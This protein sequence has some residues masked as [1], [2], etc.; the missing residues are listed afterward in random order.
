MTIPRSCI[1][2]LWTRRTVNHPSTP[3]RP[4]CP[5]QSRR[6][7]PTTDRRRRLHLRARRLAR[8][9]AGRRRRLHRRIRRRRQKT[10]PSI[11]LRRRTIA[12]AI[13]ITRP[14]YRGY[15]RSR[16]L[17][18][19]QAIVRLLTTCHGRGHRRTSQSGT[20]CPYATV[21]RRRHH[22]CG[23]RLRRMTVAT[24]VR[25]PTTGHNHGH[26]RKSQSGI[27]CPYAT[28]RRR[29]HHVR[30]RRRHHHARGPRLRMTV[31]TIARSPPTTGHDHGH[32]RRLRIVQYE[33]K[34]QNLSWRHRRILPSPTR[35]R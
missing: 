4:H 9:T 21:R 14:T 18:Q 23:R 2:Q 6:R 7:R 17:Q 29:R 10:R 34:Y 12:V 30:G 27:A 8:L 13:T 25:P 20:A 26:R 15:H 1:S 33:Y 31:A 35:R 11:L 3:R 32:H 24:I 28:V 19:Y 16:I 5:L 22:V